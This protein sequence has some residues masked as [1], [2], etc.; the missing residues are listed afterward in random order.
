MATS[1]AEELYHTIE[2]EPYC[3]FPTRL[4]PESGVERGQLSKIKKILGNDT[5]IEL[6][7]FFTWQYRIKPTGMFELFLKYC[8]TEPDEIRDELIKFIYDNHED[9]EKTVK[10]CL[11]TDLSLSGWILRMTHKTNPGDEI[12]LYLLCKLFHR[13]A[14][15]IIKTGLWT[16]LKTTKNDGELMILAKCDICL[17]L[18]GNGNTGYGEVIDV[19]P[20]KAGKKCAKHKKPPPTTGMTF[21]QAVQV[22]T[23][24]KEQSKKK[25]KWQTPSVNSLNIL[26]DT[27]KSHNTRESNGTRTCHTSH[28]LR[29]TY[30]DINYKDL[31][32][33][34]EETSP[35]QKRTVSVAKQLRTPSYPRRKSQGIITRNRLQ[36]FASRTPEHI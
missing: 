3:K 24:S 8:G 29:K 1:L 25:R 28:E 21:Q 23:D 14:V 11:P 27:G 15:I 20:N 10:N 12:T 30:R 34:G 26:P 18:V 17:I 36:K 35:P 2:G 22:E 4:N 19:T 31:D 6:S 13:H 33:K 5:D 16:T 32:V 7:W 9:I